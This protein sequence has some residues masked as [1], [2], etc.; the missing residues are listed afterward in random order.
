MVFYSLVMKPIYLKRHCKIVVSSLPYGVP[1]KKEWFVD[2]KL[3]NETGPAKMFL[4]PHLQHKEEYYYLDNTLCLWFDW[5]VRVF[6]RR[7]NRMRILHFRQSHYFIFALLCELN[8]YICIRK[9]YWKDVWLF[10]VG[11][12]LML[13]LA[14]KSS[15]KLN[16]RR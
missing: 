13:V 10:G 14:I 2:G 15:R 16:S 4:E 12:M 1:Y 3:H 11:V 8:M 9:M 5:K 6:W 7:F